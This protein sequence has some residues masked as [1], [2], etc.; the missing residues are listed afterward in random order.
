MKKTKTPKITRYQMNR[1]YILKD[2][3]HICS[4]STEEEAIM[5]VKEYREQDA[6]EFYLVPNY[7][8]L[9]VSCVSYVN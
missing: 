8:I 1:Y 3:N 4:T 6:K 5:M 2:G 9:A 7:E